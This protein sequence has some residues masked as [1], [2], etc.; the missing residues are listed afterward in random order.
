MDVQTKAT[1]RGINKY[2]K[3]KGVLMHNWGYAYEI[4]ADFEI[5]G[6]SGKIQGKLLIDSKV[7]SWDVTHRTVYSVLV[8][9]QENCVLLKKQSRYLQ[10]YYEI[11]P[12]LMGYIATE[13][14]NI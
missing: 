14:K 10:N 11:Y 7:T 5:D 13:L 4:I 12:D 9:L 1:I 3:D 8:L 2:L 6:Y